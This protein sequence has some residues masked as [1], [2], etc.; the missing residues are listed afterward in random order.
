MYCS[1]LADST[2]HVIEVVIGITAR[3]GILELVRSRSNLIEKDASCAR[4]RPN[5]IARVHHVH[6]LD[7]I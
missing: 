2:I 1:A 3:L 7:L 6:D 5:L 4:L